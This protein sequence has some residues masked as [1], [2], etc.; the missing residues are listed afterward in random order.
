M[1]GIHGVATIPSEPVT[2]ESSVAAATPSLPV[3]PAG[4][5]TTSNAPHRCPQCEYD[6]HGLPKGQVA[7]PECG[8]DLSDASR[9]YAAV[10][11]SRRCRLTRWLFFT[12]PL[13]LFAPVSVGVL[14]IEPL[15]GPMWLAMAV[16]VWGVT[17]WFLHRESPEQEPGW[18]VLKPLAAALFGA[19]YF[20]FAWIVLIQ[21]VTAVYGVLQHV[22]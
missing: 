4:P 5:I 7:C 2:I 9:Q 19:M 1:A 17:W 3:S 18:I 20:A 13:A 22:R 15:M 14:G 10:L 16:W 21:V 11:H 6:L 8:S 12:S